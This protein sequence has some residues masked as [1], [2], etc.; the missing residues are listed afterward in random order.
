MSWI[1]NSNYSNIAYIKIQH[2][3]IK[4]IITY[5]MLK[6]EPIIKKPIQGVQKLFAPKFLPFSVKVGIFPA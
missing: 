5:R 6:F 1:F 4:A 2:C 3:Q